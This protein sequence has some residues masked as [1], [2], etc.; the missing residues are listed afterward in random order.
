MSEPGHRT[1]RSTSLAVVFAA[2]CSL[3]VPAQRDTAEETVAICVE[4]L[5]V[6]PAHGPSVSVLVKNL[7]THEY[8]GTFALE[9]PDEWTIQPA[10]QSLV[11]APGGTSR[12]RY[13]VKSG[14]NRADNAYPLTVTATSNR[15][16]SFIDRR[17][18]WQV[19]RISRRKSTAVRKTGPMPYRWSGSAAD[20]GPR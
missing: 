18:R 11:L 16:R 14:V 17:L 13:L 9:V 2:L 19:L 15:T 1:L 10:E 6:T 5:L 8:R 20:C 7:A 3:A 12:L 4:S